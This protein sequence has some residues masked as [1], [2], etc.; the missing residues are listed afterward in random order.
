MINTLYNFTPDHARKVGDILEAELQQSRSGIDDEVHKNR[1][2]H[3]MARATHVISDSD[4]TAA[5]SKAL[6]RYSRL[7][8]DREHSKLDEEIEV[9]HNISPLLSFLTLPL[10]SSSLQHSL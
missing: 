2:M 9:N 5:L 3:E 7:D 6:G 8:L 4:N 10:P 1:T